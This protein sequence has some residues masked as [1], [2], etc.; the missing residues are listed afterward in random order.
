MEPRGR[1]SCG[2]FLTVV[3]G[4]V[5]LA[6]LEFFVYVRRQRRLTEAIQDLFEYAIVMEFY[7]TPAEIRMLDD[8]AG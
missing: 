7:D 8:G 3:N 6:V 1:C 5:A 4:L 2:A